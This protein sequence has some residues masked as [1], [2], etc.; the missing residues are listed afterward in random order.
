MTI[1]S[2]GS[3][4]IHDSGSQN[5]SARKTGLGHGKV[6]SAKKKGL[7]VGGEMLGNP[8][9]KKSA[10]G[11]RWAQL[12]T[13]GKIETE[14]I[15]LHLLC[16]TVY[17]LLCLFPP[18]ALLSAFPCSYVCPDLHTDFYPSIVYRQNIQYHVRWPDLIAR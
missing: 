9:K 2:K 5:A 13:G 14:S 12:Y 8:S 17:C 3:L 7:L 4:K 18:S 1:S 6:W 15:Y 11:R 16:A 10:L